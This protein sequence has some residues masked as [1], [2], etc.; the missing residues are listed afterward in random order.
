[1]LCNRPSTAP[2][3]TDGKDVSLPEPAGEYKFK[4]S[5]QCLFLRTQ[6]ASRW[7]IGEPRCYP[8]GVF[9]LVTPAWPPLSHYSKTTRRTLR[10]GL[11]RIEGCKHASVGTG[12]T[13]WTWGSIRVSLREQKINLSLS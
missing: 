1:M 13:G 5:D 2:F 9:N 3:A 11:S 7:A 12:G 8:Q 4:R 6:Q 10:Q